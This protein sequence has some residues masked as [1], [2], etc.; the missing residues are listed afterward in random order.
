MFLDTR[1]F[2]GHAYAFT[3]VTRTI[4]N[5]TDTDLVVNVANADQQDGNQI[6]IERTVFENWYHQIVIPAHT[7]KVV[8]FDVSAATW[9]TS[10]P[11]FRA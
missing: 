1:N 2:E 4:V 10:A 11:M 6:W 9:P 5:E 7:S 8:T 3:Q